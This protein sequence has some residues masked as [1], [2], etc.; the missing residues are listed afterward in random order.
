MNLRID[1]DIPGGNIVVDEVSGDDVR[2]HQDL[3]DTDRPWFYW[4]FRV[5]GAA[6]RTL[7]FT[8]TASRALGVRGPGVSFD[9][10]L[11]WRWLGAESVRQNSFV[12]AFAAAATDVRF[13]FGLPYLSSDW[14]RFLE[15]LRGHPLL[16]ERT[17]C[18]SAR[19]RRVEYLLMESPATPRHRVAMVCRHH[20]CEMMANYALEGLIGWVANDPE[21]AAGWLRAHAGFFIVPFVDK[22]GV[23]DGD[24]GKGRQPR[25]HGRDYEGASRYLET[26]AIRDQLPRWAGDRLR[27]G[28]DLHCPWIAGAHNEVI[29]QVGAAAPCVEAEQR[30]FSAFLEAGARGPLPFRQSDFLPFGTAWNTVDNFAGGRSFARWVRELPGIALGTAIEIPYANAGGAEVNPDSARAFGRDLGRALAAYLRALP[31]R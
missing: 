19:G 13:S 2:L 22:D 11:T 9:G 24:Q 7:R 27:V 20:C 29:Y 16:T 23:E 6:G 18:A 3:R 28:M 14:R 4:C 21:D 30:E 31:E 15:S 8:F 1:S 12:H 5:R 10:G 25:D 17:L 26:A